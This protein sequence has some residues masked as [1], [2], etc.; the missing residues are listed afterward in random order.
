MSD[1]SLI[2]DGTSG[3]RPNKFGGKGNFSAWKFKTLAYL[4]SIGL[5][6]IVVGSVLKGE[7]ESRHEAGSSAVT[8][9]GKKDKAT[10]D[11][12]D[13]A[14]S[15]SI[16]INAI[17]KKSEKAYAILLNLLED[18]LI[19]LI[20]HVEAGDA[21]GVWTVLVETYEAKSTAS[22]CF[23][24]DQL[25]NI[26]FD[27]KKETFDMF[28]A[29]FMKLVL[30]LKEMNEIVSPA[31]QRYVLLRSLPNDY[32]AL[33]QSLKIN[34]SISFEE[35]CTHIKDYYES[36]KRGNGRDRRSD[37]YYDENHVY[38]MTDRNRFGTYGQRD[39]ASHDRTSKNI[40]RECFLCGK[41]EHIAKDCLLYNQIKC[42][43][44]NGKGHT[45]RHCREKKRQEEESSSDSDHHDQYSA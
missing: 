21:H 34:D 10:A 33:V 31:I 12:V 30:A 8:T 5:K 15:G 36:E 28:K 4:Q 1:V 25:M 37:R 16:G 45:S 32:Q 22:L 26:Q 9:S 27:N 18:E 23:T 41:K 40:H 2:S 17:R 29:R 39:R 3:I 6:D 44:C 24:L 19:D 42:S 38:A 7:T 14:G 43:H 20:A 35:T 13:A 11:L